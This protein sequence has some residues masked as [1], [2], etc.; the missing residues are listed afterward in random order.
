MKTGYNFPYNNGGLIGGINDS[1]IETFKGTPI[2]SITKETIQNALDAKSKNNKGAIKVEFKT[3]DIDKN[4]FPFRG[5]FETILKNCTEYWINDNKTMNFL[6]KAL[7]VLTQDTISVLEIA[8]YN[9]TG[10]KGAKEKGSSPFNNLV[11]SSGVSNKSDD[12]GG[13]FGIGK[14]APYTCS[15]FRTVLYSTLDE[16]NVRAVQGV[17]KLV[18]HKKDNRDTQ[19]TGFLGITEKNQYEDIINRPFIDDEVSENLDK[20]FIRKEVGTSLFVMGFEKDDT[21]KQDIIKATIDF[22]MMAILEEK[23]EVL[24]RDDVLNKDI[25]INKNTIESIIEEYFK[26]DTSNI[27]LSYYKAIVGKGENTHYRED[28]FKGMGKIKLYLLLEE[29][30]PK[31]VAYIRSNGMKIIDKDRFRVTQQFAGV[32]YFEGKEI[33]KFIRSLENP[34]HDKIEYKRHERSSYAKGVLSDISAWIRDTVKSLESNEGKN[35][36]D[37]EGIGEYLPDDISEGITKVDIKERIAKKIN[38]VEIQE[39]KKPKKNKDKKQSSTGN[40]KE[41]INGL[42]EEYNDTSNSGNNTGN[43]SEPT[44]RNKMHNREKENGKE[45]KVSS[46]IIKRSRVFSPANTGKYRV[47]IESENTC[48]SYFKLR[49][50][51]E[52]G[53]EIADIKL[54]KTLDGEILNIENKTVGPIKFKKNEKKVIEVELVNPIR[55]AMEVVNSVNNL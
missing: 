52:E 26:E 22:Y 18:T 46:V 5:Q 7:N 1:G 38:K 55:C 3:S 29:N 47:I 51:G 32:L 12:A 14:N 42:E 20:F 37:V 43:N 34:S 23:L 21:W 40:T 36:I 49:I 33:N 39:V 41:A 16:E 53:T 44:G 13:S 24:V 30:L 2:Y 48:N 9:T 28:D 10:L 27:T 50:V 54:A 11:K 15:T 35:I 4:K 31:K 45:G 6:E 8:D 25:V 19:G 17:A